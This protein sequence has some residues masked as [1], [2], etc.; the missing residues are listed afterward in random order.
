M[1]LSRLKLYTVYRSKF[2][3]LHDFYNYYS[4]FIVDFNLAI[5]IN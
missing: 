1:V 2:S 3:V 4:V 5:A